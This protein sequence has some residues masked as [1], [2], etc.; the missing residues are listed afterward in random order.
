MN[1]ILKL[2]LISLTLFFMTNKVFALTVS[3][4]NI[5]MP[6][7]T[8]KDVEL[9]TTTEIEVSRIEFTLVYT[10]YDVPANFIVNNLYTDSNPNGIKHIINFDTPVSGTI[11]LGTVKINTVNSPSVTAGTINI[12]SAKALTSAGET[13][14]LNSQYIKVTIG[15]PKTEPVNDN[16]D[17]NLLKEIKSDKVKIHLTKD[18]FDYEVTID[19]ELEE[20]DLEPIAINDKYKVTTSTQKI[21]DLED[22]KIT[23]TVE[24]NDNHVVTYNIKVNILKDIKNATI[25]NNTYKEKNTTIDNNT[26][27]EKNTYQS[28]WLLAIIFFGIALFISLIFT[29]KRK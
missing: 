18:T 8:S 23:I 3:D 14:N 12:H 24:D 28:K 21:A 20:L 13:I 6:A 16:Y 10:T 25:D 4:S 11:K 9:S 15:E 5:T 1:K 22:N 2:I 7:G 27:K 19:K 26:Y 17:K 29:K